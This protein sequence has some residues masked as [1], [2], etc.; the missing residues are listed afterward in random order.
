MPVI[1]GGSRA[2]V[3]SKMECFV[4]IALCERES[5]IIA[6]LSLICIPH[7]QFFQE[8]SGLHKQN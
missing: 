3:T 1:T 4:I 5:T 2:A 7:H 8:L 6:N